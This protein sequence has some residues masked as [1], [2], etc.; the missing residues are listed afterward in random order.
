MM[1]S[2]FL[3]AT[4]LTE[5]TPDTA[6]SYDDNPYGADK[7]ISCVTCHRPHGSANEHMLKAADDQSFCLACHDGSKA[8]DLSSF[9]ATGHGKPGADRICQEC[10]FPHGTGQENA[11]KK[12][13]KDPHTGTDKTSDV[14]SA[15]MN[16]ACF[17]CHSAYSG[18]TAYYGFDSSTAGWNAYIVGQSR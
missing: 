10:H 8:P 5:P 9:T 2:T 7:D 15:G 18:P 1:H 14:S 6:R 16:E 17:A 12:V 11:V 13:I 4:S 3:R